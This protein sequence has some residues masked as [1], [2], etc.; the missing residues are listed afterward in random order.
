M[1]PCPKLLPY[2]SLLTILLLAAGQS[3][4]QDEERR[5]PPRAQ[6]TP[7]RQA[8]PEPRAP[9]PPADAQEAAPRPESRRD[10]RPPVRPLYF[11]ASI[12]ELRLSASSL[13]QLSDEPLLSA[14]AGSTSELSAALAKLGE[15]RLL[16]LIR[17]EVDLGSGSEDLEIAAD[18]P[19]LVGHK[20]DPLGQ[21]LPQVAR[22]RLGVQFNLSGGL[23]ADR[24]DPVLA[25]RLRVGLS[26]TTPS[27]VPAGEGITAS[28]KRRLQS[29]GLVVPPR[30]SVF[31][32]ADASTGQ[33]GVAYV[34]R[35]ALRPVYA[36]AAAPRDAG[37]ETPVVTRQ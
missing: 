22:E 1:R 7:P 27:D 31:V 11:E 37:V 6:P 36:H 35:V 30:P 34:I 5:P 20:T 17:Q 8:R 4:A 15:A 2:V 32:V 33:T 25:V 26:T 14:Q 12:H 16:Y 29:G 3:L 13:E 28:V 23:L 24:D 9:Q 21:I 10:Q 19:Y 18:S